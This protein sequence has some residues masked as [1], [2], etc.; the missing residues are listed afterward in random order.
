MTP[1]QR[2][3]YFN[4]LNEVAKA[5]HK[6]YLGKSVLLTGIQSGWIKSLLTVWGDN[7]RGGTAPRI[8]KG[9]ACWRG[10]KGASWSDKALE[11]FTAALKQARGEGFRGQ[12]VLTRAHAIL[13]PQPASRIIDTA[14]NDDDA[15][16]IEQCVLEAFEVTDPVYVAGLNYYSTHK[17]ISDISREL[18]K[19]AP[20]LSDD[21]ARWRVRW[22]LQ[23]FQA[24]V[25][26]IARGH[27]KK[28]Y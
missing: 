27:L 10:V 2:R 3:K 20:W 24:K 19:I 22:C 21:D 1:Q 13:W 6:R 16:F 5:N 14:L 18:Q 26:L 11:R 12:Q 28:E 17:K 4:A 23:I 9:H 8:P 15:D 25:F 7:I